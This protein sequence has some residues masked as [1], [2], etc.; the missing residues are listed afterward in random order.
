M[1][2]DRSRRGS[3]LLLLGVVVL[4]QQQT[5]VA[6]RATCKLHMEGFGSAQ[7]IKSAQLSCSGGTITASAHPVLL[8]NFTRTFSGVRWSNDSDCGIFTTECLLT[9]CGDT[10][11][12]FP[13]AVVRNV[14]VSQN[15]GRLLCLGGSSNSTFEAALFEGNACRPISVRSDSVSLHIRGSNF[16]N[17]KLLWPDMAGGALLVAGGEAEVE[18]SAFSGNVVLDSGGAVAVG[19]SAS[20]QVSSTLFTGNKGKQYML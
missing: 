6:A 18:S 19:K 10:S 20:L 16:T 13:S 9:V 8:A 1:F 14:N 4:L 7:G 3:A 11:A 5:H 2:P 12:T 15:I 17:N